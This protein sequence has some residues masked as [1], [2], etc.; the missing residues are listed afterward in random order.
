MRVLGLDPGIDP[1]I[2]GRQDREYQGGLPAAPQRT[3]TKGSALDTRV[4][5]PGDR[6]GVVG[7]SPIR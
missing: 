4:S 1:R 6:Q 5:A 2:Q 7:E 3:M